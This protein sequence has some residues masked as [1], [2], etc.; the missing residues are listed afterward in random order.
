MFD[1]QEEG[2]ME[3]YTYAILGGGM[4]AGYAAREMAKRGVEPGELVIIS[5]D[6]DPPYERPPLS[7]G[8]LR[9][10]QSGQKI[11]INTPD[12]Y[13]EHGIDLRL[14]MWVR[15][16]DLQARTIASRKHTIG[17]DKLLIATGAWPRALNV[18]GADLEGV[19]LL[20]TLAHSKAIRTEARE[21][22]H[23]VVIG[24]GFIG[25]E[26]AAALTMLGV[27]CA[28]VYREPRVMSGRFPEPIARYFEGYYRE[29]GVELVPE[30]E[31]AAIAGGPR[32]TAVSLADG[33]TLPADLVV[34]GIGVAPETGL[35]ADG[36][37][38]V[39][40]GIVANE[41][42]ETGV[43]DV[44]VAGD[45]ARYRDL[46]FD[47]MRRFEHEDNARFQGRHVAR[48]ML[49]QR[50][51]F[52]HVPHFYSDMFDLSW[53][54]WGDRSLGE[55]VVYRGEVDSGRFVAWWLAP[56]GR[57]VASFV[58]GYPEDEAELTRDVIRQKR[59]L[60]EEVLTDTS[61]P[62]ADLVEDK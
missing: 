4:V 43:E 28:L 12:F 10:E 3:R 44:W 1:G 58:L 13:E 60:P 55:R 36:P 14:N 37:L 17:F 27:P 33:R 57:P 52:R 42:L 2:T 29:R 8:Y 18:P 61:R 5:M 32:V 40:D 38:T 16:V 9:G 41:Y 31:V 54:Y 35:F 22:E 19:H 6:E 34:A 47:R 45:V 25:M 24:A 21:A 26:M 7:K 11:L 50:K 59:A 15:S 48:A 46:M 30:A 51:P 56:D 23:A 39:D 20:R 53:N 49:G 62:L